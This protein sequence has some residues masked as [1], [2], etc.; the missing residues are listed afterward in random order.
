MKGTSYAVFN[1][2]KAA[3]IEKKQVHKFGVPLLNLDAIYGTGDKE[4]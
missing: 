1:E 4:K 3:E 2:L